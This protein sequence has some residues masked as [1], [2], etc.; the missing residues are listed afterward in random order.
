MIDDPGRYEMHLKSVTIERESFPT[1]EFYPFNL[2]VLRRTP[3]VPFE[4]PVTLLVGENGTGKS[5][6]LEAIAR[7]AAIHI[8]QDEG[9]VR[10]QVNPYENKLYRCISLQWA[11]GR[12]PG[13]FFGASV[14]RDFARILDEW[15]SSDPGQLAYFGGQSLLTQSHGQS[16]MSFF[17]ARYAVRGLY[18]LDEPETALSPRTQIDLLGVL[19]R[20]SEAGH[21]QF[22]I[23]THSPILMAC[24]GATIYSF[25][26]V[27]VEPIDYEE[28][29]HY[30]TYRRFMMDRSLFLKGSGDD[31]KAPEP[32]C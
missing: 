13:S 7:R 6:L 14:F 9:R 25:D 4:T 30:Q 26:R 5:T 20:M 15:A 24:P 18:L 19:A 23:A 22:V 29:D 27:P 11:D 16:L 28:T 32:G 21:A 1:D 3:Q 8:W 10:C 12:V 17:K 31:E 2:D